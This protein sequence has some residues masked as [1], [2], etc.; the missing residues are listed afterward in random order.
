MGKWDG[1]EICIKAQVFRVLINLNVSYEDRQCGCRALGLFRNLQRFSE[2]KCQG[3]DSLGLGIRLK[4]MRFH[5]SNTI[6]LSPPPLELSR[7]ILCDFED[8]VKLVQKR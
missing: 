2:L 5:H 7:G 4:L 1:D 8:L 3:R 6:D